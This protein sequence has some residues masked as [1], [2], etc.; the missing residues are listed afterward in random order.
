MV[1]VGYKS[2][3]TVMKQNNGSSVFNYLIPTSDYFW[4]IHYSYLVIFVQFENDAV[5]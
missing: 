1:G 4:D 3:L 5:K 2:N